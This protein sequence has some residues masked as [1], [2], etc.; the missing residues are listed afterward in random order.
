MATQKV[1]LVAVIGA[2]PGGLVAAKELLAAGID[3]VVFEAAGSIGG[4]WRNVDGAMWESLLSNVS[5]HTCSF[6]DFPW[7]PDTRGFPSRAD[8]VAY[9]TRYMDAFCL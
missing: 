9:L 5:H 1:R 2:G 7:P 4:L 6:S 8:V 3:V